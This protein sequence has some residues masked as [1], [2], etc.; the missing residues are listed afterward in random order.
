[1]VKNL[2]VGLKPGVV[3]HEGVDGEEGVTGYGALPT[4][5]ARA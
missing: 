5:G 3:P 1:M 2:L 4:T